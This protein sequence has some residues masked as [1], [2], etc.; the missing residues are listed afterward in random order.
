MRGPT[1]LVAV[2]LLCNPCLAGA[3]QSLTDEQKSALLTES[4]NAILRRVTQERGL[5]M[6][7][8]TGGRVTSVAVADHLEGDPDEVRGAYAD[9][10]ARLVQDPSLRFYF[11]PDVSLL[12]QVPRPS[13]REWVAR[14]AESGAGAKGA[15]ALNATSTNPAAPKAAERSGLTDLVGL[16]LDTKNLIASNQSAV[17]VS[18]NALALIG[19]GSE[20]RSAPALYREHDALRRLGG[21]FTFGAK[22]PESDITG[23]TGLPS[24]STLLD[25][26]SWDVKLRVYGDRDPRAARWYALMLGAMGGLNEVSANL[27]S[28]VPSSD[29]GTV[30]M[31]LSDR[32]GQALALV[33]ERLSNSGQVSVKG[34]GQHLTTETGRNKYSV[35]VLGD[36]G[37]G[38]TDL[39]FNALYSVV[40]DV[41]VGANSF[42][43][44]KTWSAAVA[45]NHLAVKNVLVQGRA[46]EFS[47]NAH[48]EIPVDDDPQIVERKEV[49]RVV[50][51]VGI[52]WGDS[53]T[54]PVSVTLTSDPNSLTKEKYVSGHIGVSYDFGA[55]KSLFKPQAGQ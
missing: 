40:D 11:E 29:R 28:R 45:V 39:T 24:A 43:A 20:T 12:A 1:V 25:V 53:V 42:V 38:D 19:L 14:L 27:I 3:Q 6:V 50:G 2:I 48:I 15:K 17:S 37:F 13:D 21:T 34:A 51:S 23:F 9:A 47:L 32:L 4:W 41:S 33:R 18:L 46:I 7:D 52:P 10:I 55:L 31:L 35:A 54:I 49:W 22:L 36:K 16:A 26:V 5:R 30:A 44:L 8:A